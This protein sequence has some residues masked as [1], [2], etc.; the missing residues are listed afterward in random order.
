MKNKNMYIL[1]N[2]IKINYTSSY[3]IN[4]SENRSFKITLAENLFNCVWM[5][6][7]KFKETTKNI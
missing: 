7:L 6:L 1:F 2:K 4:D 5:F 3:S